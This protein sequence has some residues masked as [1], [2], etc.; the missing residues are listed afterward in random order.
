M[1]PIITSLLAYTALSRAVLVFS[2]ANSGD[3]SGNASAPSALNFTQGSNQ[4]TGS[5][6][7]AGDTRDFITF[8]IGFGLVPE[9]CLSLLKIT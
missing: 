6:T 7:S 9:K 3:L 2:E 5:V 4:I 1:K 8:N